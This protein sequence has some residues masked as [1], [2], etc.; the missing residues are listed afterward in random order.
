MLIQEIEGETVFLELESEK[1]FG[2]NATG[3]RMLEVLRSG[4]S[5]EEACQLLAGEFDVDPDRLRTDL[6]ALVERLVAKGLAVVSV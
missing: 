6:L 5:V 3:S 4:H 2:L 1:Y